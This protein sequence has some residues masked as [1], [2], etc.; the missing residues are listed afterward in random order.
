MLAYEDGFAALDWLSNAFGFRERTR[1]AG[2][3]GQ[4]AHGEMEAGDGI[5]MLATPTPQY[6]S[7]RS[8][9]AS[10][11]RARRW[12]EV[13]WVIDGVLVYVADVDAHYTRAK[14]AWRGRPS[15]PSRK[16][17]SRPDA[18]ARKISKDTAGCSWRARRPAP[19]RHPHT[20]ARCSAVRS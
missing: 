2:P 14:R 3:D 9:R 7:P 8:H 18:T 5:V 11:E 15:F 20:E 10:C 16:T 4:L 13:P 12:S 1:M 17:A 6:Q 19:V